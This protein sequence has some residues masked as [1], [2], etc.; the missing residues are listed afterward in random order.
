[1][2][3]ILLVVILSLRVITFSFLLVNLAI[4]SFG[5]KINYRVS[6]VFSFLQLFYLG[7]WTATSLTITSYFCLNFFFRVI[8]VP[9]TLF[10][11]VF[12]FLAILALLIPC[13]YWH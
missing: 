12:G 3:S 13:F 10:F 5:K 1:V 4:V 2:K 8:K 9:Q 6:Y 11:L 7:C